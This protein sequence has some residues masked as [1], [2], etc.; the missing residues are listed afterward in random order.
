MNEMINKQKAID[1]IEF[2]KVYM[3]AYKN[4]INKGNLFEQYNKGL[5]D[6]IKAIN[7]LASAEPERK[8]GEWLLYESRSDIYDLEGICTWGKAYR[9]SECGFIHW[10]IEDFGIYSFCPNCGADMRDE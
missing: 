1:A 4:G 9:C 2:E 10:A 8:N 3:T 7:N 5:N 6:A